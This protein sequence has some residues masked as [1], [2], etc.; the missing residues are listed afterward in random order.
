M[1][2]EIDASEFEGAIEDLTRILQKKLRTTVN[3]HHKKI[4]IDGVLSN[5]VV[6]GSLRQSLNKLT[7]ESYTVIS[8]SGTLV[9]KKVRAHHHAA[10]RKEGMSPPATQSLPYF[11]PG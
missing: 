3:A 4:E 10:K 2:L 6:R 5:S 1:D 11:F 7:P 8:Q 9:V